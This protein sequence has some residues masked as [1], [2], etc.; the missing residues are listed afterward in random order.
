MTANFPENKETG[1]SGAI[2]DG[3]SGGG[4]ARI[5]NEMKLT[6][7]VAGI[8]VLMIVQEEKR[9]HGPTSVRFPLM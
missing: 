3:G 7:L 5:N 4:F 6:K 9:R 8:R 2:T 1:K